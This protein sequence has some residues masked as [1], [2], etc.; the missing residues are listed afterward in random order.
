MASKDEL[1]PMAL[2]DKAIKTKV[3]SMKDLIKEKLMQLNDLATMEVLLDTHVRMKNRLDSI[4]NL[5]SANSIKV[6]GHWKT[7]SPQIHIRGLEGKKINND[8]VEITFGVYDV[9][10]KGNKKEFKNYSEVEDREGK[11]LRR[12]HSSEYRIKYEVTEK[13]KTGKAI[14]REIVRVDNV[15][16]E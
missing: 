15:Q 11:V 13:I 12:H 1:F 8:E 5:S 6:R 16:G 2:E 10:D 4:K 3:T 7:V 14:T 9:D